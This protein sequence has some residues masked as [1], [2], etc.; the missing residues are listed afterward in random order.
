[1][2]Q[3]M[4]LRNIDLKDERKLVNGS[5]GVVGGFAP[6]VDAYLALVRRLRAAEASG[7]VPNEELDRQVAVIRRLLRATAV[8]GAQL[9]RQMFDAEGF[10][11]EYERSLAATSGSTGTAGAG[12]T[13]AAGAS[14]ADDSA[15]LSSVA[16]CSVQSAASIMSVATHATSPARGFGSSLRARADASTSIASRGTYGSGGGGGSGHDVSAGT[17]DADGAVLHCWLSGIP[18]VAAS[19]PPLLVCAEPERL[20]HLVWERGPKAGR[21]VIRL[22]SG[23]PP[24]SAATAAAADTSASAAAAAASCADDDSSHA[25]VP[26]AKRP[27]PAAD[28]VAGGAYVVTAAAVDDDPAPPAKRRCGVGPDG[29]QA[30]EHVHSADAQGA[31]GGERSFIDDGYAP[32]PSEEPVGH[33]CAATNDAAL[34]F[35]AFSN[36]GYG[37]GIDGYG[38]LSGDIAADIASET[39]SAPASVV[40]AP[41]AAEGA[42]GAANAS[43]D[44]AARAARHTRSNSLPPPHAVPW[45]TDA[46]GGA[47]RYP[48]VRFLNGRV[49]VITPQDF[50]EL[51]PGVGECR[52][53]QVPLR[54]AWAISIHKSQGMSLDLVR[55]DVAGCFT[56]GQHYVALSRARSLAGLEIE[57]GWSLSDGRHG[58]RASREVVFLHSLLDAGRL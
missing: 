31:D 46:S 37:D 50:G 1:M 26:L 55:M 18:L 57:P 41:P 3:V 17:V 58:V 10:W 4:L 20:Q 23:P 24:P 12:D 25:H 15:G 7:D 54:L 42:D 34:P 38:A 45:L 13:S 28:A 21:S 44:A 56:D 40:A 53:T 27:R 29:S 49:E 30:E 6:P 2:A 48:R 32:T 16:D 51:L 8:N 22:A 11:T 33:S 43:E 5:R 52:L 19:S 9:E 35:E 39:A 47:L 14:V 36:D